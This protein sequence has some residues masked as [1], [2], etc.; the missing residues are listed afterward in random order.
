MKIFYK[1]QWIVILL[2]CLV[3]NAQTGTSSP[4][5]VFGIGEINQPGT[6]I[7]TGLGGAGIALPTETS[8]NNINPASYYTIDSLSF[9]T[10]VG[11][12]M[13]F[14][15][16]NSGTQHPTSTNIGLNFFA[17][18]FRI[19]SW[20]KNS[21]GVAPFSSV[22]NSFNTYK[23]VDNSTEKYKVNEQ[24][25][26]GLNQLYWGNAFKLLPNL[27]IGL[28]MAFIFGDIKQIEDASLA[29]LGVNGDLKT[30]DNIFVQ[31]LYFNYGLQYTFHL[32]KS[33]KGSVGGIFGNSSKLNLS[34]EK[35]ITDNSNAILQNNVESQSTFTLPTYYGIGASLKIND[36]LLLTSDYKFY[37]WSKSESLDP[38]VRLVN[39]NSYMAGIEYLPSSSFRDR[40]LKK[41]LY[42]AGGYINNTYMMVYGQQ[43]IDK[44]L[45]I[46][47]GIP[48]VQKKLYFNV[49]YAIGT[50]GSNENKGII[51]EN[52]QNF[53][54]TISINDFW[55]F[56]PK[57]D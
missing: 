32:S 4:Y 7:N 48:V 39:S 18:G 12:N 17:V 9:L 27:S 24:G 51:Q 35:T 55:F 42:R 57:F 3:I 49:A 54:I 34:H 43:I 45:T 41:V 20:W 10:D 2:N 29:S 22:G 25:S 37:N 28:N 40:G 11:L 44:G 38:T 16:F 47:L 19:T 46:G 8:L 6:G 50:K 36:K 23:N 56:K 1:I 52:Y 33:I 13:K 26:G 15:K 53:I 5:S 31:K 30:E 21:L 14:S